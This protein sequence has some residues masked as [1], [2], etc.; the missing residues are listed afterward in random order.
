MTNS[1]TTL[2]VWT[3]KFLLIFGKIF[4]SEAES[5]LEC[6][7]SEENSTVAILIVNIFPHHKSLTFILGDTQKTPKTNDLKQM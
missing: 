5:D 6:I 7:L 2:Q 4:Q 3:A 1:H